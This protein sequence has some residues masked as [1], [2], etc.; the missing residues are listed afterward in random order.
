MA[1]VMR[2]CGVALLHIHR[3]VKPDSGE[4]WWN[5]AHLPVIAQRTRDIAE[6]VQRDL[7]LA[8]FPKKLPFVAE[9]RNE[10]AMPV[11]LIGASGAKYDRIDER[12]PK[13]D[14]HQPWI[15]ELHL[16]QHVIELRPKSAII[17]PHA[18]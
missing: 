3:L 2:P 4:V 7:S 13:P 9:G 17:A 6:T 5:S 10:I 16:Q 15:V 18:S 14:I 11:D 8:V 12:V 1:N